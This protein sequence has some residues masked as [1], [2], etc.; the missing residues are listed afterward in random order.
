MTARK[1]FKTIAGRWQ[2]CSTAAGLPDKVGRRDLAFA[3]GMFYAGFRAAQEAH[4]EI[5][6]Y[7]ED[8]AMK[9]FASLDAE[10]KLVADVI[11]RTLPPE[12][13]PQ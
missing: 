11:A 9:L 13:P 3:M 10:V 7:P 12:E 2:E 5:A 6:D 8:V 4:I 1:P